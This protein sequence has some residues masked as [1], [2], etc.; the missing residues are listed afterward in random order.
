MV[1]GTKGEDPCVEKLTIG[2]GA[3]MFIRL[4][5]F[6]PLL[7]IAFAVLM[8]QWLGRIHNKPVLETNL[9]ICTAY[10]CFFTAEHP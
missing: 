10:I 1:Q 9:T 2:G 5:V 7:G 6:G 8:S 4:S 3:W